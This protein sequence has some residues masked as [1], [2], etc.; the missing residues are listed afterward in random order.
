MTHGTDPFLVDGI[1]SIVIEACSICDTLWRLYARAA[2][3]LHELVGKHSDAKGNGSGNTVELLDHEITI[4]ESSLRA[5]RHELRRHEKARH[6][7]PQEN[8][9][10]SKA[11]PENHREQPA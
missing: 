4:A 11:R 8:R 5:V 9:G 1:Q 2:D 7:R 10:A 3:N 6:N